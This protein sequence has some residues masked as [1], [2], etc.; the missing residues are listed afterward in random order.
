MT[1]SGLLSDNAGLP[2]VPLTPQPQHFRGYAGLHAL[3]DNM[4]AQIEVI[5]DT[6]VGFSTSKPLRIGM[7]IPSDPSTLTASQGTLLGPL[8]RGGIE[9]EAATTDK[10]VE[11]SEH[12]HNHSVSGLAI[13]S[14]MA[15]FVKTE[16]PSARTFGGYRRRTSATGI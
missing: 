11:H 3:N 6:P 13:S 7:A 1:A 2:E 5:T 15:Q 10:T 16:S 14:G 4:T 12:E 9:S 8:V